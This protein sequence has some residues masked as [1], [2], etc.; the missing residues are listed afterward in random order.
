MNI[1]LPANAF[2]LL[3]PK[4]ENNGVDFLGLRQANLDMMADSIPSTN[5]VTSYIRPFSLLCWIFWKFHALCIEADVSEPTSDDLRAF[6]ERIEVLFTWGA[7]LADYPRIPGKQADP[8]VAERECLPLTF[9]DW[10]RV[11]TSTSLIAALW[12]GPASKTVTGLG[13]L[14]PVPR[15]PGFFRAVERGVAL[16]EAF[17]HL[18]HTDN[19]RY[20]QLLATL[21]VVTASEEDA[22]A[23]WE[24]WSPSTVSAAEQEAF[25]G[26][27]FAEAAIGDYSSLIGK[28]SSTLALAR[29]HLAQG[30]APLRPDEVRRGMFLSV[31]E[32]GGVY[33]V[34]AALEP[35][36][37][38]WIVL[39][40]RQLQRLSL[41][42]LLSWCEIQILGG[43]RET[44]ALAR[45][46]EE[47]WR[48]SGFPLAKAETFAGALRSLE[49]QFSSLGSFIAQCRMSDGPT[50]FNLMDQ[51]E[52]EFEARGRGLAPLCLHGLLLCAAFAHCLP[53]S[54][55]EI[56]L[57]GAQRLSLYHLRRRLL[58]LG[59]MPLGEAI[60]F[61]IEAMVI[62]QH[63]ATAVNRFDGQNQ[64]LRLA[65][66][67][68]GLCSLVDGP[69]QPTVTEDRLP[70]LLSLAAECRLIEKTPDGRYQGA[71]A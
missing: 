18:L 12:Y 58:A 10:S 47:A 70:T 40:M 3:P 16:A 27:F 53:E 65:I 29:L 43:Q 50:P 36:R 38:K 19:A 32:A 21:K 2:F 6:R 60:R 11:Q 64:R 31:G 56:R 22:R 34:P 46:F 62:S 66:E 26:A 59:G 35:A 45:T 28:R 4:G 68:T 17:D 14:M 44:A 7:R 49:E 24:L 33:A 55:P 42:T 23:L 63:F 57:G 20:Q 13:F 41:E 71:A 1:E 52:A 5:N 37:D 39:Q 48:E 25:R 15:K 67:E 30:A 8:P 9:E 51:I 54:S 61:I 69:W